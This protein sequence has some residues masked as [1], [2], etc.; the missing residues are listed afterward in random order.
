MLNFSVLGR[1]RSKFKIP[2]IAVSFIAGCFSLSGSLFRKRFEILWFCFKISFHY[3]SN[4]SFNQVFLFTKE[5]TYCSL[6][7]SLYLLD[8]MVTPDLYI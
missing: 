2:G 8:F 1:F 7:A 6:F 5:L 4:K 3:R